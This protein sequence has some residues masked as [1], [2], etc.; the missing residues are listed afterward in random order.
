M[1]E[2]SHKYGY[3][4][5]KLYSIFF[6]GKSGLEEMFSI[7]RKLHDQPL[8]EIAGKKVTVV[9]DY[10]FLTRTSEYGEEYI[11]NLPSTNAIKFYLEDGSWVAIRPSGTEPK[12]KFYYESVSPSSSKEASE[13]ITKMHE[14]LLKQLKI[15][16]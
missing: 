16:N 3:H 6:K 15:E 9:E 1:D 8:T 13:F 4:A 2:I 10:L 7:M 12:C 11:E 14:S 5:D